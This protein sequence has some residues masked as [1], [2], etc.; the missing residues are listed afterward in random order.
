MER[1]LGSSRETSRQYVG[2]IFLCANS[3]PGRLLP[4]MTAWR[5]ILNSETL[6][7]RVEDRW[8]HQ[9]YDWPLGGSCS[10]SAQLNA[11]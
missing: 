9:L 10:T 5:S 2:I 7:S 3:Q 6:P 11:D 4:P 1:L 8:P